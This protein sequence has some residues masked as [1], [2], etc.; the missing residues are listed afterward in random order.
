MLTFCTILGA[1]DVPRARVLARSVRR[2]HSDARLVAIPLTRRSSVDGW[3]TVP[4]S[5]KRPTVPQLVRDRLK[6]SGGEPVVYT[7]PSVW[8]TG[9]LEPMLASVTDGV[10]ACPRCTALPDDERRPGVADLARRGAV[11]P[12]VVIARGNDAATELL[13]W[14]AQRAD[15]KIDDGHLLELASHRFPQLAIVRDAGCG[16][17]AWNLHELRLDGHDKVTADGVAARF[18]DFDGFRAD[19]PFWL[20]ENA[21]RVSVVNDRALARLCGRYGEELREQGWVPPRRDIDDLIRLGNGQSIDPVVRRLWDEAI[22]AGEPFGDPRSAGDADDFTEWMRGPA[23]QGGQHGVTRYLL[24]AYRGRSDLQ[25]AFPDLDAPEG[26]EIVAWSWVHGRRELLPSL[27]PPLPNDDRRPAAAHLGVNVIGYL[28]ETLGLAEAA[29]MYI[30]GLTTA[31]VPV[32][33][34]AVMPD[35]PVEDDQRSI[36]RYGS[37]AYQDRRSDTEPAFNLACVNADALAD[38]VAARGHEFLAGRPTIGQW[39]WETDV[40]PPSWTRSFG[41]VDEVWVYSRFVAENLGRALPVPVVV[42]PPAVLVPDVTG[43]ELPAWAQSERFTFL[44]MLDMFST[45]RRKN[46]LG[47]IT[48]FT[49]AFE[50]GE[51][52]RLLLKTINARFR[53]RTFDELRARTTGHPDIDIV[54]E[55]ITGDQKAA[56]LARADCYVSLHRS[57]GFGLPLAEAMALGTPV[58]ATGYSG[59]L[60]FTTP[61]NSHLVDWAPTKVGPGNEVYPDLGNWAEPDLDH[62]AA[63]MRSVHADQEDAHRRAARARHEIREWYAPETVGAIAR[64]R[65]QEFHDRLRVVAA[66]ERR[67]SPAAT[68]EREPVPDSRG[69]WRE[70]RRPQAT[71]SSSVAT[72]RSHVIDRARSYPARPMRRAARCDDTTCSIAAPSASGVGSAIRPDTPS[73]ISSVGP[74]ASR[75]VITGFALSIASSVMYP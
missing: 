52:P 59:N 31:N 39:G 41:L 46:A 38:L 24:E 61:F 16:L 21:D 74:P 2:H 66:G 57:E 25:A 23:E 17:S 68:F 19:R 47:V 43:V 4:V 13:D 29:R 50:P 55:F 7:A 69:A 35:L 71:P 12:A 34:T 42:V 75:T 8:L 73:S 72:T 10:A 62:A 30:E 45:E 22:E 9:S 60:D 26:A 63:L 48:A 53:R 58:I 20:S 11:S 18:F 51:G 64:A 6:E 1:E 40:L 36:T 14:W 44:F 37:H 15:P 65:L 56:L 32:S 67:W 49:R 33:T 3:E 70:R 27:L 5:A 54:D 28:G